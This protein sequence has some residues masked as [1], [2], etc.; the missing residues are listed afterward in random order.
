MYWKGKS[1]KYLWNTLFCMKQY[2]NKNYGMD[3]WKWNL[4]FVKS[5]KWNL[6]FVKSWNQKNFGVKSWNRFFFG[7]KS[8]NDTPLGGPLWPYLAYLLVYPAFIPY[9]PCF[10]I[11]D[12]AAVDVEKCKYVHVIHVILFLYS[13]YSYLVYVL[14]MKCDHYTYYLHT[15][16]FARLSPPNC[17]ILPPSLS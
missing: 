12:E 13:L 9:P 16:R 8:W 10:A 17:F 2:Q 11:P 5:W 7:V 1:K 15:P 3:S 14:V 6:K 4:K